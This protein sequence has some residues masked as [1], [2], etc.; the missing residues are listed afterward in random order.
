MLQRVS[1][2]AN[3][4]HRRLAKC[5]T[6][7]VSSSVDSSRSAGRSCRE[8]L[9]AQQRLSSTASNVPATEP[10]KTSSVRWD[11]IGILGEHDCHSEV[12]FP[13]SSIKWRICVTAVAIVRMEG[14]Q[15]CFLLSSLQGHLQSLLLPGQPT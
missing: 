9:Q 10:P 11:Y 2:F 7:S 8:V 6:T 4:H 14:L 1:K 5:C 13:K 15:Q 12:H 3:K